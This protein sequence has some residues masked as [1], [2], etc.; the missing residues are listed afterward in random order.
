MRPPTA[1][2]GQGG[3]P[4]IRFSANGSVLR[5][6]CRPS[7]FNLMRRPT[8]F[9]RKPFWMPPIR[10]QSSYAPAFSLLAEAFSDILYISYRGAARYDDCRVWLTSWSIHC[11]SAPKS[12]SPLPL[13]LLSTPLDSPP[14]SLSAYTHR[15]DG[16]EQVS[17]R[18]RIQQ[19]PECARRL[20]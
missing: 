1:R 8:A 9:S 15:H 18:E 7:E 3:G 20:F 5:T 4:R 6:S 12:T 16:R 2:A 11:F 13:S 17:R 10:A 19:V 14:R